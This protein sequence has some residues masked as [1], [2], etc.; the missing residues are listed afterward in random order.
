MVMDDL[1]NMR[2][3]ILG[4]LEET[5]DGF[6]MSFWIKLGKLQS[7][8]IHY[9]REQFCVAHCSFK[10]YMSCFLSSSQQAYFAFTY[11][12]LLIGAQ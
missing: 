10:A 7:L 8:Q 4:R 1:H 11:S 5:N 3:A 6:E 12:S 2:F 9:L